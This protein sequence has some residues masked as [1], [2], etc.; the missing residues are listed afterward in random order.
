MLHAVA[1]LADLLRQARAAEAANMPDL[2]APRMVAASADRARGLLDGH[3]SRKLPAADAQRRR[4]ARW[5]ASSA[6][7]RPAIRSST[8]GKGA[9]HMDHGAT[10]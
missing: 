7:R 8:L 6:S 3:L 9:M 1:L 5:R 4:P 2:N 10:H